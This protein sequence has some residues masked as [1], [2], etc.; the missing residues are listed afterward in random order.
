MRCTSDAEIL[1]QLADC[2]ALESPT[3]PGDATDVARWVEEWGREIGADVA[4]QEVWPGADNVIVTLRFSDGP[5]LVFNRHMDVVDPSTQVWKTPPYT[6]TSVGDRIYGRG[7]VDAKGSLVAMLAAFERVAADPAGL[8]GEIVLTAVVA[9][10]A[11][12]LGSL[13]LVA[14][15]FTADAAVVGEPTDLEVAYA[16]KGTY[17]REL[18]FHGTAAHSA[19]PWLGHNAVADAAAFVAASERETIRLAEQPH[20]ALGPATMTVT[21]LSGGELQNTVPDEAVLLVDRR[22]IPGETHAGCDE[23]LRALLAEL[24]DERPG[25]RIEE[26]RV[27]VSTVPSQT[28]PGNLIVQSALRATAAVRD[29]DATQVGFNAGCDMSKLVGAGIPTVICGPGSLAQAHGPNE[30]VLAQQVVDAASIY[31]LIIRDMLSTERP[32]R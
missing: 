16:H 10:E 21:K 8:R 24:A 17:M 11:G 15:G 26:P 12:G 3:P 23:E 22:M 6:A 2:I 28:E 7:A 29:T 20:P 1:A 31:E 30:Y 18:T 25:L 4:K 32:V 9:E 27:V 14:D 13:R 19:S 5:R